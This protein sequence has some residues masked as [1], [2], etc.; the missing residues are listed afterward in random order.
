MTKSRKQ[1]A[2]LTGL[3][4]WYFQ[5]REREREREIERE[6]EKEGGDILSS[7]PETDYSAKDRCNLCC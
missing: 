5:E 3:E 7:N 1:A 4:I 6:R 2:V